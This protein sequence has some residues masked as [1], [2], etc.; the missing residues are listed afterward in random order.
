VTE[1]AVRI[2]M[3][4]DGIH[5]TGDVGVIEQHGREAALNEASLTI[6]KRTAGGKAVVG[7]AWQCAPPCPQH[8]GPPLSAHSEA[9]ALR[10]FRMIA[11]RCEI[12]PAP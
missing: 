8:S 6:E 3:G 5:D 11:S 1:A 10:G 9:A 12:T 7:H 4:S 2:A